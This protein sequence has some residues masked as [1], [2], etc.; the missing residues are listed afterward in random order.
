MDE[1]KKNTKLGYAIVSQDEA[2]LVPY[3]YVYVKDDGTVRELH[4]N[5]RDYLE[6]PF[7]P[8]DS[9]RPHVKGSYGERD[10]WGS[11]NGFCLRSKIPPNVPVLPPP[12]EDPSQLSERVFLERQIKSAQEKGF[13]VI[14][15]ADGTLIFR[16]K[17][18][19]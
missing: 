12:L 8:A 6:K 2:K 5:E 17:P 4:Q 1:T 18:K 9:A 7:R 19:S 3:P 15:N 13:D 14:E 10:G 11:R 16:R